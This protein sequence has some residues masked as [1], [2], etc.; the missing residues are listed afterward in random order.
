MR[1]QDVLI[2]M[3]PAHRRDAV[4]GAGLRRLDRLGGFVLD[5]VL[6]LDG[7]EHDR[8]VDLHGRRDDLRLGRVLPDVARGLG[9]GLQQLDERAELDRL[10]RAEIRSEGLLGRRLVGIDARLAQLLQHHCPLAG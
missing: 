10:H 8:L 2:V 6:D 1:L 4:E 5:D 3:D 9:L 7:F